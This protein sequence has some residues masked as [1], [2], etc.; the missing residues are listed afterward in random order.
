MSILINIHVKGYP[1]ILDLSR[2][3]IRIPYNLNFQ[4]FIHHS[5]PLLYA[6]IINLYEM[7]QYHDMH[8]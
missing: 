8:L 3:H 5:P 1:I 6:H 4:C 2:H 7:T